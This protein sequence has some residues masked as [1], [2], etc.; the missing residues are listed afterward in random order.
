MVR[1]LPPPAH[2]CPLTTQG[3]PEPPESAM[4]VIRSLCSPLWPCVLA[5]RGIP[6]VGDYCCPCPGA[7]QQH[8]LCGSD[9]GLG[10]EAV[11]VDPNAMG[12]G[13]AFSGHSLALNSRQSSF[14]LLS[15]ELS[16]VFFY[17][18]RRNRKGGSNMA[19]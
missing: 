17:K 10:E 14:S 18:R 9:R 11:Q 19:T 5:Q 13:F 16:R 15:A 6:P 3:H 1:V 2:A 12:G 8:R 7:F 4:T